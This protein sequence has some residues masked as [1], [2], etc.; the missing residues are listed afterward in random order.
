MKY[1]S[2]VSSASRTVVFGALAFLFASLPFS[3]GKDRDRQQ[4]D[5]ASQSIRAEKTTAE[6]IKGTL[7][8]DE[9]LSPGAKGIKVIANKN[10]IILKGKV[11]NE[12]E[13]FRVEQIARDVAKTNVIEN[14]LRIVTE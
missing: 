4:L 9:S 11:L 12:D 5:P 13:K 10:A 3:T 2:K 6:K 8:L 7:A 1:R 14:D